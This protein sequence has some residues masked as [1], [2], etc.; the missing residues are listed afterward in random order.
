MTAEFPVEAPVG[1]R[2][3][4]FVVDD[5]RM[6]AEVVSACLLRAGYWTRV[7]ESPVVACSAISMARE[8]P[9]LMITDYGMPEMDGLELVRRCRRVYPAL[10]VIF[11]SGTLTEDILAAS[12]VKP[13]AVL[14]KP[15][16]PALLLGQVLRLLGR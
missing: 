6:V 1:S 14:N 10:K 16:Q 5:E 11:M 12:D 3:L 8:K 7:F 2:P 15:F 9:A 13:D 4:I